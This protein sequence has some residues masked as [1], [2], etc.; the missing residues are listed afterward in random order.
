LVVYFRRC[1]DAYPTSHAS[2]LLDQ[3]SA[4]DVGKL[5]QGVS[6]VVS[7][8]LILLIA[9]SLCNCKVNRSSLRWLSSNHVGAHD[10]DEFLNIL[11]LLEPRRVAS[12]ENGTV[13]AYSIQ[14]KATAFLEPNWLLGIGQQLL[15]ALNVR[16]E[17]KSVT[18]PV[19]QGAGEFNPIA[20]SVEN[21][22]TR[23][24]RLVARA[25]NGGRRSVGFWLE[26]HG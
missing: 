8:P 25:K 5:P 17:V 2:D 26:G 23:L 1:L 13:E 15:S 19:D 14:G 18:V 4:W 3:N 7:G 11:E 22:E 10:N 6:Q 21:L 16:V 12:S 20:D 9:S 24:A